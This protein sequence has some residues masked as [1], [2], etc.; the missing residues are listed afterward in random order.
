MRMEKKI[1]ESKGL[2]SLYLCM[3]IKSK[4]V[5]FCLIFIKFRVVAT[6]YFKRILNTPFLNYCES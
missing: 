5:M 2:F 3:F 1:K 4:F 6:V